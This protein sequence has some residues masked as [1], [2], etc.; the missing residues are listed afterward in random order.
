MPGG[1]PRRERKK[2]KEIRKE[3]LQRLEHKSARI[4]V[5]VMRI[6]LF[7]LKKKKRKKCPLWK[8]KKSDYWHPRPKPRQLMPRRA[9]GQF[10][11][12]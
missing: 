12:V 10:F 7:T 5:G 6:D 4:Y 8:K 11:S 9:K 2:R 3:E 1:V